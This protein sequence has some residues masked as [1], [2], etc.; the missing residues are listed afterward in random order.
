M[1]RLFLLLAL[2][3]TCP[4]LAKTKAS[5][6]VALFDRPPFAWKEDGKMRGF[7]YAVAKGI[8]EKTGRPLE[9]NLVPVRRAIEML[10]GGEVDIV[11]MTDQTSFEEMK[12]KKAWIIEISTYIFTK[13]GSPE[14]TTVKD[15]KGTVARLGGGC[16]DLGI[17]PDVKWNDLKSYEQTLDVLLLG[18]A[19]AVCGT[20]SFLYVAR[21]RGVEA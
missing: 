3:A 13:K 19:D 4:V 18:R 20:D 16:S 2:I 17:S 10:R 7:H 1:K 15:V 11:I 9:I 5:L 6:R 14:F 8:S 12:T 21:S